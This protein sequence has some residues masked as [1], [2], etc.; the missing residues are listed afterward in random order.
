MK[1]I[2]F[3]IYVITLFVILEFIYCGHTD[4]HRWQMVT[5][6]SQVFVGEFTFI[7]LDSNSNP[8]ISYFTNTT[9]GGL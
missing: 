1:N 4:I 7:V 8:Y 6:V 9:N 3:V 5:V 2:K